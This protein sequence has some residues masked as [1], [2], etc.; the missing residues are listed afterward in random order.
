MGAQVYLRFV[1]QAYRDKPVH[2]L[3]EPLALAIGVFAFAFL[4]NGLCTHKI[5]VEPKLFV[6]LNGV[7]QIIVDIHPEWVERLSSFED[8]FTIMLSSLA[9]QY[10]VGVWC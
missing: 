4:L 8:D 9:C 6:L 5:G 3:P 1:F 10:H 7:L 2:I